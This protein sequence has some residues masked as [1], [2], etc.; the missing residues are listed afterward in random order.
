MN[1]T[2]SPENSSCYKEIAPLIYN[3]DSPPFVRFKA[4][5]AEPLE[6]GFLV[7]SHF[8][9]VHTYASYYNNAQPI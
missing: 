4:G 3:G 1:L 7:Q 8:S 6:H 5:G 2:W 9:I